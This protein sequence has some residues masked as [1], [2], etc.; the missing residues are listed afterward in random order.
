MSFLPAAAGASNLR[1]YF[2]LPGWLA[3]AA[4]ESENL[5]AT[6]GAGGAS[7][8]FTPGYLTSQGLILH[9]ETIVPITHP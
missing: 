8:D 9:Q 2:N 1:D 7:R 3:A 6:S 5:A 4:R